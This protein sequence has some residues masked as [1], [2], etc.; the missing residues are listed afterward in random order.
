MAIATPGGR[1]MN[2][3]YWSIRHRGRT[4]TRAKGSHIHWEK[5]WG[6]WTNALSVPW[7]WRIES[8]S[9]EGS[10]VGGE[11]SECSSGGFYFP[12]EIKGLWEQL[13]CR[14]SRERHSCWGSGVICLR[15]TRCWAGQVSTR[16]CP[17]S[18]LV[19]IVARCCLL[20][21]EAAVT[22]IPT[23]YIL[24]FKYLMLDRSHC[25]HIIP[26]GN[27][28]FGGLFIWMLLYIWSICPLNFKHGLLM[29]C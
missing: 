13:V 2:F 9:L 26:L 27:W 1:R 5:Q 24:F 20:F 29:D 18:N 8:V 15:S 22:V 17:G 11:K 19:F 14:K 6:E 4:G 23:E 10:S 16:Y 25:T 28:D 7:K 3:F 12:K 21:W